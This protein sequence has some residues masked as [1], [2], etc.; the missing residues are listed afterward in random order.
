[1]GS[2][3]CIRDRGGVFWNSIPPLTAELNENYAVKCRYDFGPAVFRKA[4]D[5]R[6][7]WDLPGKRGV[8][9]PVEGT[10]ARPYVV[11]VQR[12]P[13]GGA[14]GRSGHGRWSARAAAAESRRH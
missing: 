14:P 11:M 12:R 2:E 9:M 3:M 10:Q 8:F 4:P 5:H 1:M 6:Q 13:A 7:D